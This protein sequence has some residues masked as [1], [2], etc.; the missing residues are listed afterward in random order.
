LTPEQLVPFFAGFTGTVPSGAQLSAAATQLIEAGKQVNPE[1]IVNFDSGAIIIFQILISWA[2]ARWRPFSTMIV[3]IIISAIGIGASALLHSGWPITLAI[4]IFAI[5][6]MMAG[7][8]SQE[9]VSSIAPR[10][11]VAMYMGYLFVAS[12]LGY[13]FGGLLSGQLYGHFARDLHRP[14]IMWTIFGLMG[15]ATAAALIVYDRLIIRKAVKT[16]N[17]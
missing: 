1:Y 7:P 14:D 16:N 15:F 13:L 12:A 8:K 4:V 17:E 6:E 2:I 3:G 10:D 11:K 9:Y 5:G